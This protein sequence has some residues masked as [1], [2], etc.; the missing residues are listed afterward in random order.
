MRSK[1]NQIQ[2]HGDKYLIKIAPHAPATPSKWR[3]TIQS[4]THFSKTNYLR[5]SKPNKLNTLQME[6]CPKDPA[7]LLCM[8]NMK[9]RDCNES[10][11]DICAVYG[12]TRC[13]AEKILKDAGFCYD[14]AARRFW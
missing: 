1:S 14:E 6:T 7:M 5:A 13:Q 11:D 2:L 9:L 3:K 12:L 10:L 8:L 4:N